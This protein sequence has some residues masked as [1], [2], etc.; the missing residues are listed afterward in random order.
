MY[1][2]S[3]HVARFSSGVN[4]RFAATVMDPRTEIPLYA[5]SV[6]I[7]K[8]TFA[9]QSTFVSAT[10]DSNQAGAKRSDL[11]SPVD[12][13]KVRRSQTA[14]TPSQQ[15]NVPQ[16][17]HAVLPTVLV[18]FDLDSLP[19]SHLGLADP[20]PSYNLQRVWNERSLTPA[21]IYAAVVEVS[22]DEAYVRLQD[23]CNSIHDQPSVLWRLEQSHIPFLHMLQVGC[24]VLLTQPTIQPTGNSFDVNFTDDTLCFYRAAPVQQPQ[25]LSEPCSAPPQKR[26]RVS[27]TPS[28]DFSSPTSPMDTHTLATLSDIDAARDLVV[29]AQIV[30][31][32][33]QEDA[34]VIAM[35]C[36][37]GITMRLVGKETCERATQL[38]IGDQ[39]LFQSVNWTSASRSLPSQTPAG[40]AA[41]HVDNLSTM[42]GVLH[43][44]FVR[45]V[46][47]LR[48]VHR[49][50]QSN[51]K[52]IHSVHV[53]V[54]VVDVGLTH[55]SH[56][57]HLSV[58]DHDAS[59]GKEPVL[60]DVTNVL[61]QAQERKVETK[62]DVL[63]VDPCFEHF[64]RI[65]SR[66]AFWKGDA[67]QTI[68]GC[69]ERVKRE[70]WIMAL[71]CTRIAKS[72]QLETRACVTGTA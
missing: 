28:T 13:T 39:V 9:M 27:D 5:E 23:P 56:E 65:S 48:D 60:R 32:P 57:V 4:I 69:F 7:A 2:H 12:I 53:C 43:A 24:T 20:L 61:H 22:Q 62:L 8:Q 37:N 68:A 42:R 40:W 70:H 64:F 14:D 1:A 72:Y 34:H 52:D 55:D 35:S 38:R 63:V 71:T 33:V 45:N 54:R 46:V 6:A 17:T 41:S 59:N 66:R 47:R 18:I 51:E 67:A 58:M 16:I 25:Q 36:T 44:S 31:M 30:A 15:T 49:I 50:M 11:R 10:S 21:A 3:R 29:F 19:P 26:R